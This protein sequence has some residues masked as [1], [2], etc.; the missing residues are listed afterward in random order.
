M[1]AEE[2]E[3]FKKLLMGEYDKGYNDGVNNVVNTLDKAVN[4]IQTYVKSEELMKNSILLLLKMIKN[5][6]Q[7]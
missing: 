2:K 3:I 5:R 4:S 6:G 1:E 7:M